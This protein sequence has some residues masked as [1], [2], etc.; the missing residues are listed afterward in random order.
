MP[1]PSILIATPNTNFSSTG[2]AGSIN[3]TDF[4][5]K[6]LVLYFYPKDSTPGCTQEGQDFRDNYPKFKALNAEIVGV[7]RDSVKSHDNFKCKQEFP[8]ELIS[9]SDETLCSCYDVIKMKNMYGKQVQGIERSTFLI[10][11]DSVLV[12]EWRKVSVKGH[13]EQ[14]LQ[15]LQELSKNTKA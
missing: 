3:L 8:F 7:S 2:I 10:D 13:W 1:M 11:P 15:D 14:V 6:F 12:R 9:D 4:K 5:G